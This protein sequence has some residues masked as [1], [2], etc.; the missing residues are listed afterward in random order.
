MPRTSFVALSGRAVLLL[1]QRWWQYG[2]A[3]LAAFGLE[4]ACYFAWRNDATLILVQLV[5]P[6]VVTALTYAFVGRDEGILTGPLQRAFRRWWLVMLVDF[7][8]QLGLSFGLDSFALRDV[9]TGILL[10]AI[11]VSL[12]YADVYVV[13]EDPLDPLLFFR[14]IGR[15]TFTAWN[16]LENIARSF[17]L[18]ALQLSPVYVATILQQRFESHHLQLAS[19]W[20][21]LPLGILITPPLSALTALVYLDATGRGAKRTCGE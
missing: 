2:A 7:I 13:M 8:G 4:S 11:V 15:S 12:I 19:F 10:F 14:A 6:P 1:A 5:F 18:T 20:A 16:G 3:I 9:V 21:Q 17:V